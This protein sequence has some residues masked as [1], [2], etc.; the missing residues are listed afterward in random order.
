MNR[1]TSFS[2]KTFFCNKLYTSLFASQIA[3]KEFSQIHFLPQ[4]VVVDTALSKNAKSI[5][6]V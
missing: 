1:K 6:L 4:G 2:L 5:I 3:V